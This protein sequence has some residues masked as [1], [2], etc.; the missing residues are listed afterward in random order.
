MYKHRCL[1]ER[2]MCPELPS[3]LIHL[4][5]PNCCRKEPLSYQDFITSIYQ[6]AYMS[7]FAE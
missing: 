2:W 7:V 6:V 1:H 5:D 3:M 4:P